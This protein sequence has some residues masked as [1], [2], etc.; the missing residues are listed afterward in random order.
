MIPMRVGELRR[1]AL[2]E[3]EAFIPYFEVLSS[4]NQVRLLFMTGSN[5][6]E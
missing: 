1:H 5:G 4:G 6:A 3:V 2:R